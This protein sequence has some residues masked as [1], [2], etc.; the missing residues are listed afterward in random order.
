MAL[1]DLLLGTEQA[2]IKANDASFGTE[3]VT[4]ANTQD[5]DA[6]QDANAKVAMVA[7][8]GA[9]DFGDVEVANANV[10]SIANVE[11]TDDK[12]LATLATLALAKTR[13]PKTGE[14]V[15]RRLAMI[16]PVPGD[17]FQARLGSFRARTNPQTIDL[18]DILCPAHSGGLKGLTFRVAQLP[19][20]IRALQQAHVEAVERGL[21]DKPV[22]Q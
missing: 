19:Q 16:K 10:A 3:R 1:R 11:Q 9:Q 5:F 4:K 21:I 12:T 14:V 6:V 18:V 15:P 17:E 20:L 2:V 7:N 22:G 13:D 8:V